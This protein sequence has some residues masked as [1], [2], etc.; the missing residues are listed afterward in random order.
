[1][2]YSRECGDCSVCC[3]VGAVPAIDK[4]AFTKCKYMETCESG[5]CSIFNDYDKLPMICKFYDC[6]WKQGLGGPYDKPNKIG[7]MFTPNIIDGQKYVT[8]V[9]IVEGG[10]TDSKCDAMI[11]DLA[12]FNVPMIVSAYGKKPPEDTGDWVIIPAPILKN[13]WRIAGKEVYRW[14]DDLAMYELIKGK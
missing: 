7:V 13:C 10:I 8:A 11:I 4:P 6:A 14:T 12:N 2:S 9:E 1:M 5:S 3:V